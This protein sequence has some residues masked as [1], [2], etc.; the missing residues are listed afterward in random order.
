MVAWQDWPLHD[1]DNESVIPSRV[2]GLFQCESGTIA[3][4]LKS[5]QRVSSG[6]IP[7]HRTAGLDG[8]LLCLQVDRHDAELG[9]EA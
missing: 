5:L 3:H 1:S 6:D 7:Q 4:F 2:E 9:G 8:P